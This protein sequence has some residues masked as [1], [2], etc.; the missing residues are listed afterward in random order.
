M[1]YVQEKKI[2]DKRWGC[3]IWW[4]NTDKYMGKILVI[5]PNQCT[6]LHVHEHKDETMYVM[7]GQLKDAKHENLCH[8]VGS[9]FHVA[10]GVEHRLIAGSTGVTLIEVS[11]PHPDDSVRVET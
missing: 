5:N 9:V 6:S 7:Q 10:P 3:E 8:G 2:V 11:T 4:A 1:R